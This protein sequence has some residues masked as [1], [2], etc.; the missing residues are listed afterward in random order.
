MG[1][2]DSHRAALRGGLKNLAKRMKDT[3]NKVNDPRGNHE[4]EPGS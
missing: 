3:K 1:S 2:V 4:G